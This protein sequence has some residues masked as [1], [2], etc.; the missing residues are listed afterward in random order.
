MKLKKLIFILYSFILVYC[1]N[2]FVFTDNKT[3]ST[4]L[5]VTDKI[6]VSIFIVLAIIFIKELKDKRVLNYEKRNSD[7]WIPFYVV[8]VSSGVTGGSGVVG[9]SMTGGATPLL[10]VVE[11]PSAIFFLNTE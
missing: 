7:I 5:V 6:V 11:T 4:N 3:A 8:G 9:S 2:I 1:Y 10:T